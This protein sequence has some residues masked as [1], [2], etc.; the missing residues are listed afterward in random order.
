[1]TSDY[2]SPQAASNQ[3]TLLIVDRS[4]DGLAPCLHEF[5]YQA[6]VYDLLNVELRTDKY[7]YKTVD[8]K[9]QNVDRTVCSRKHCLALP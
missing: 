7:S 1:M 9:E 6:M 5:T 3:A 2:P 4:I 8:N